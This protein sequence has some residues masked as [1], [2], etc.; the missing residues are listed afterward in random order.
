MSDNRPSWDELPT[1][2]CPPPDSSRRNLEQ[3]R[4]HLV[5]ER[6]RLE[7]QLSAVD[8]AIADLDR[9]LENGEHT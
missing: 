1:I 6:F 5:T 3:S 2:P 8:A 4:V 9:R 7:A